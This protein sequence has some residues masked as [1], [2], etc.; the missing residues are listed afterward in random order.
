MRFRLYFKYII[1][2][3]VNY[4]NKKGEGQTQKTFIILR[5]RI[6]SEKI[7]IILK[8]LFWSIGRNLDIKVFLP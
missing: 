8:K 4:I 6:S 1:Y 7:A 3:Q 2:F 5:K